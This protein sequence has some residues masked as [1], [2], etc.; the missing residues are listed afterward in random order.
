VEGNEKFKPGDFP[1]GYGGHGSPEIS[2]PG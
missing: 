1:T 2:Y